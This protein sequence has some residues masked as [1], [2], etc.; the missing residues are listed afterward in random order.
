MMD[1]EKIYLLYR[2]GLIDSVEA[3]RMIHAISPR[4]RWYRRA[5]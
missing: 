4:K 3:A 1:R 2:W 5:A